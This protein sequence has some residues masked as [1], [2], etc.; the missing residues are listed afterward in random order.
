M[1]KVPR[2]KRQVLV[3]LSEDVYK[4]LWELIRAKHERP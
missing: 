4:R 1:P 3:L 2:G